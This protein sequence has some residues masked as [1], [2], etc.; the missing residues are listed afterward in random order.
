MVVRYGIGHGLQ[1]HGLTRFG[2]RHDQRALALADGR[3]EIDDARGEVVVAVARETEFLAREKRR[4]E[5]E[6]HAVTHKV[7]RE[8]VDL[9]HAHQREVFLALAR[10]ADGTAHG[11]AGLQP[12]VLDLRRRNIDV[13][14]R[15]EIVVVRRAEESVAVRHHFKNPFTRDFTLEIVFRNVIV[16]FE[17]SILPVERF[18]LRILVLGLAAPALGRRLNGRFR[19]FGARSARSGC[20]LVEKPARR[21]LRIFFGLRHPRPPSSAGFFCSGLCGRRTI[22]GGSG[23]LRMSGNQF[24]QLA[25]L[26]HDIADAESFGY[27]A[28]LGDRFAF[29]R[30]QI[31]HM[32]LLRCFSEKSPTNVGCS[33][34]E[35]KQHRP[36]ALRP[37]R[38]KPR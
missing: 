32:F 9:V 11:V 7:G 34:A 5:F 38:A 22:A 10:R 33:D 21:R 12:E 1:Q 4:H 20:R 27:F 16:R 28:Q 26:D 3:K 23:T 31:L 15:I 29:Q 25:F 37:A 36:L 30:I 24:D 19:N 6:L 18:R 14:G 13:V 8:A 35:R 17:I 2:L